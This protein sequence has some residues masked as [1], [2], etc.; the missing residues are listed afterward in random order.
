M[1][2][3]WRVKLLLNGINH[4]VSEVYYVPELKNNLLTIGQ[5][6]EEG[7]TILIQGGVC[8]IYHPYKG[9]IIE[10]NMSANRMFILFAQSQV[11]SQ[12]QHNECL[13]TNSQNL[14]RLWHRR[15]GDLS[16]K[17]LRTLQSKKKWYVASPSL[18]A[19]ISCAQIAL[20]A[21]I[22]VI[23]YQG[24]V[25]GEQ[26]R[27]WISSMQTFAVQSLPCPIATKGTLCVLLM[28]IAKGHGYIF[29][30]RSQKH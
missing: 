4:A 23:L 17:G 26:V 19:Q 30:W 10:T 16:Y 8:K 1:I 9:L 27:Y 22:T 15:Y 14:P 21:N 3:K 20:L 24:R 29:W 12:Q 2:G 6:Q 25:L 28:T 11:M 7:L 5:L 13:H 18:L